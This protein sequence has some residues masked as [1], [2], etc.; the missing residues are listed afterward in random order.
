MYMHF[1]EEKRE[2]DILVFVFTSLQEIK[3]KIVW[4]NFFGVNKIENKANDF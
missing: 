2:Y 3:K 1:G 4:F